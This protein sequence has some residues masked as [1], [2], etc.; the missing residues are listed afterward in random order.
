MIDAAV[1]LPLVLS[2]VG[3]WRHLRTYRIPFAQPKQVPQ[4][5]PN[6]SSA[7][8]AACQL[9][10]PAMIQ[11]NPKPQTLTRAHCRRHRRT[12]GRRYPWA[13]ACTCVVTGAT[14]PPLMVRRHIAGES[15]SA[16]IGAQISK[17]KTKKKTHKQNTHP[18][19]SLTFRWTLPSFA[20][21]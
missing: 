1:R 20:Q 12:C 10:E 16:Q 21:R 13:M 15:Q 11:R 2:Q 6:P 8:A 19:G 18:T 7:Q 4:C 17:K 14:P 9:I 5:V 3:A